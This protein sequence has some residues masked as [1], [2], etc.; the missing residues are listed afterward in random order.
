MT[1]AET[2]ILGAFNLKSGSV[3]MFRYPSGRILRSHRPLSSSILRS[4]TKQ[5]KLNNLIIKIKLKSPE[6]IWLMER[7]YQST[8]YVQSID[9]PTAGEM[10]VSKNKVFL[11][12]EFFDQT[13]N[14]QLA[15]LISAAVIITRIESNYLDPLWKRIW[16]RMTFKD[17]KNGQAKAVQ[18][19]INKYFGGPF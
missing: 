8:F 5:E 16:H 17:D 3:K 9:E 12:Y 6:F 13:E 2:F 10:I 11:P 18:E 15:M 7:F 14:G 1:K 19:W 4:S